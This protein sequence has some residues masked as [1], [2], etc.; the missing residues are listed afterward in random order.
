MRRK[1]KYHEPYLKFKGFLAENKIKQYEIAKLIGKNASTI[2][3]H[4]NGTGADF[5]PK[6]IRIICNAYNISADE[7]FFNLK[8]SN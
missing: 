4:I 2:N 7:Y 1:N 8:V 5:S 3:Q 6:D